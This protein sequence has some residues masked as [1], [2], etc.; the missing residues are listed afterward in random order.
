MPVGKLYKNKKTNT[1]F[2]FL[3][4]IKKELDAEPDPGPLVRGTDPGIRIRKKMSR[5]PKTA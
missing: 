1:F 2:A 4:S 5:I 3:K